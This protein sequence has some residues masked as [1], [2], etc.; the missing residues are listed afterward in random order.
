MFLFRKPVRIPSSGNAENGTESAQ[1]SAVVRASN[2]PKQI[3]CLIWIQ[4]PA[5]EPN[6]CAFPREQ[7]EAM[8]TAGHHE[9]ELSRK[10]GGIVL[11]R[12]REPGTAPRRRSI[13]AKKEAIAG[14]G[15]RPD[16]D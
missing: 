12:K 7:S 10:P 2:S 16:S 6:L 13:Y 4:P 15:R 8:C 5:H 14:A 3:S 9:E 11:T 1:D